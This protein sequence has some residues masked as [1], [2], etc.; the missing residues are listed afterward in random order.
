MKS[1]QFAIAAIMVSG[2]SLAI[3]QT[4]APAAASN[5]SQ[6]SAQSSS[7]PSNSSQECVGPASYC[8]VFFGGS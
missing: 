1:L 4:S 5:A 3:A 7:Q 8:T 2:A 6:S